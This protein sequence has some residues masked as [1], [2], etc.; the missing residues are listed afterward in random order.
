M[1]KGTHGF[2]GFALGLVFSVPGGTQVCL[3]LL[4]GGFCFFAKRHTGFGF[5]FFP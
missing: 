5:L 4:W 2:L 1:P 3:G